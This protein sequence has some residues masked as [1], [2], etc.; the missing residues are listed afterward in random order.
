MFRLCKKEGGFMLILIFIAVTVAVT[1]LLYLVFSYIYYKNNYISRIS[2]YIDTQETPA[3]KEIRPKKS[4]LSIIGNTVTKISFFDRYKIKVQKEL[5][6]AHILLKGEEFITL[7]IISSIICLLV[8]SLIFRNFFA[9]LPF[10]ILGWILPSMVVKNIKRKRVRELNLQL[11]DAIVL[12]SNSLKAGY[13]FFQAIEMVSKEMPAPISEEFSKVQKEINLGYTTEQALE[14]LQNR[15]ESDD[16]GLVI[17]AVLIQ[18]QVG[19]NLAEILDNISGTIRDRLK[20]KGEIRTL[21]AQ[22]RIS[23]LI[24]SLVPIG[25]G[26]VLYITNPDYI[27]LLFSNIIGW[28][29][30]GLAVAMQVVGIYSINKIIKIDV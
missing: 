20:I 12:I 21:T 10:L 4:G 13:S 28:C 25:L 3:K 6:K 8:F 5:L 15:V 14:N 9:G 16:L 17:T 1:L 18:R 11:A 27:G 24:I 23:G 26:V 22:G 29:I 2:S 30:I 7:G 19:G